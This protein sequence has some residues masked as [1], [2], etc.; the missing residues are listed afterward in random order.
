MATIKAIHGGKSLKSAL[1]YVENPNKAEIITGINCNVETALEEM[2]TTKNMY[3]KTGGRTYIHL[4]QS[5]HKD[6]DFF[7]A[8]EKEELRGKSEKEILKAKAQ[9][10]NEIAQ[11]LIKNLPLFKGHEVVIAT[12][13]D[14]EHIHNH[15]IV[16]SVNFE[17]GYKFQSSAHDLQVIKDKSDEICLQYGLSKTEKGKTFEGLEHKNI[18]TYTKEARWVQER[19]KE[20][21]IDSYIYRIGAL[22]SKA[23]KKATNKEEFVKFLG[24]QKI[25][26]KWEDSRKY[27]T[28]TDLEREK[29]NPKKCKVRDKSL[30]QYFGLGISKD[31]LSKEFKTKQNQSTERVKEYNNIKSDVNVKANAIMSNTR[32]EIKNNTVM[33]QARQITRLVSGGRTPTNTGVIRSQISVLSQALSILNSSSGGGSVNLGLEM[34]RASERAEIEQAINT[35]QSTLSSETARAEASIVLSGR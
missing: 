21:H 29:E 24:E 33:T 15:I 27:I 14:R 7:T 11:K 13:I 31:T 23:R 3:G 17:N 20:K 22:V 30:N 34:T 26:V 8:E 28:F 9:K 4:V 5:W 32:K 2:E 16:N 18:S 12:H 6:E 25:G 19:A 35:L 10:A 1:D